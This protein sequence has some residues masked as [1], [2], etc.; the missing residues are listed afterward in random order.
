MSEAFIIDRFQT[1]FS[2]TLNSLKNELTNINA[3]RSQ[4]E[5]LPHIQQAEAHI[6]TGDG[7]FKGVDRSKRH[8]DNVSKAA[9]ER[10][11]NAFYR[12]WEQQKS[13]FVE[14]KSKNSMA[15][16]SASEKATYL[17]QR[18]TLLASRQITDESS[19]SLS[20]TKNVIAETTV[21]G[22]ETAD[23]LDEQTEQILRMQNTMHDTNSVLDKSRMLLRR[24]RRRLL[25]NKLMT[26]LIIFAELA[27]LVMIIFI[28]YYS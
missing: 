27:I 26:G 24:M 28:K 20:R 23:Q 19:Q 12:E 15:N 2:T 17:E 18:N 1:E 7:L 10:K 16:L 13:V 4:N 6:R 9:V 14:L 8:L 25:S 22:M 21:I 3:A 11:I 5:A